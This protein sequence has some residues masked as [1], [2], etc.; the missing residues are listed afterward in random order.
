MHH[1]DIPLWYREVMPSSDVLNHV[2]KLT[3]RSDLEIHSA[4]ASGVARECTGA[5]LGC[6]GPL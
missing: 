3:R 6:A 2:V 5:V 1:F 4:L